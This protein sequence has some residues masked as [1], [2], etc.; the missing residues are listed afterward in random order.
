MV[1][2]ALGDRGTLTIVTDNYYEA[3]TLQ[4]FQELHVNRDSPGKARLALFQ[5]LITPTRQTALLY[6]LGI[7]KWDV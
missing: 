4:V 3:E 6:T 1:D 2:Y 5:N 7:I